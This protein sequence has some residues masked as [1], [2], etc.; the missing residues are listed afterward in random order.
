VDFINVLRY[1][2]KKTILTLVIT[3]A[4]LSADAQIEKLAGPRVGITMITSGS[5]ASVI[6]RDV[7][8]LSNLIR[9]KW[10]ISPNTTC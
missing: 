6:R 4:V 10:Y 7:P 8:F 3:L 9:E 1:K 5:L 2:M